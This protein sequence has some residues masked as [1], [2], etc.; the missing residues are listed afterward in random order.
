MIISTFAVYG[1]HAVIV[2]CIYPTLSFFNIQNQLLSYY[3]AYF[4]NE[5]TDLLDI[6]TF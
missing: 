4:R 5:E 1:E 6:V 2:L 3:Y